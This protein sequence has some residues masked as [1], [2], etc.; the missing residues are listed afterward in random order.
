MVFA[1]GCKWENRLNGFLW[2]FWIDWM[3]LKEQGGAFD[4]FS[5]NASDPWSTFLFSGTVFVSNIIEK[6]GKQIFK[7]FP[8]YDW[9][10]TTK[11]SR[12]FRPQIRLLH[13][14]FVSVSNITDQCTNGFSWH[15]QYMS[16]ITQGTVWMLRLTPCK[17]DFLYFLD[18]CSF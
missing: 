9:H 13:S 10:N 2:N 12:I 14:V 16:D 15:L 11:R 3:R 1:G 7:K 6:T 18:P 5:F 4:D 8:G 17:Q